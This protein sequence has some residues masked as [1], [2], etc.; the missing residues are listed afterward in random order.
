MADH[1]EAVASDQLHHSFGVIG[2]RPKNG[3]FGMWGDVSGELSPACDVASGS[4]FQLQSKIQRHLSS[5]IALYDIQDRILAQPEPVAYF[6][7]RLAFA[8]EL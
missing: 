4:R 6:P 7:V 3:A 5:A 2:K 8:N 1:K